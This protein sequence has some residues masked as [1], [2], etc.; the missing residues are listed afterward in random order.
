MNGD[1]LNRYLI[2]ASRWQNFPILGA[3]LKG[4]WAVWEER[5]YDGNQRPVTYFY[6]GRIKRRRYDTVFMS[7]ARAKQLH[8][9]WVVPGHVPLQFPAYDWLRG[10]SCPLTRDQLIAALS[11][12][13]QRAGAEPWAEQEARP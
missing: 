12:G 1:E 7:G 10:V 6:I 9:V 8:S 13:L 5:G 11:D 3:H 2:P 4:H